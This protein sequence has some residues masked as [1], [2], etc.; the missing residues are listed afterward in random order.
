MNELL[1]PNM[2][3]EEAKDL[4]LKCIEQVSLRFVVG[5]PVFNVKVVDENG[6]RKVD[7]PEANYGPASKLRAPSEAFAA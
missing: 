1:Q 5:Q 4:L 2:S 7:M 3:F 6:I